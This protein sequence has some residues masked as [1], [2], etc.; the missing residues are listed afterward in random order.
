MGFVGR[1]KQIAELDALF[2]PVRRGRRADKGAAVLLRGRRRIGKSRLATEFAARTGAPTVA[3]EAARRAPADQELAEFAAAIA[4]SPLPDAAI[5]DGAAPG[6]LTAALTLLDAA[7]PATAPSIVIIDEAPWLLE[8]FPGGAGELQRVWDQ[9]LSRKPVLLLLVGSDISAM[10]Q[11]AGPDQPFYGRASE[12]VLGPLTPAEVAD[13]TGTSGIDAFDALLITGGQ[14]LIAQE[15]EPGMGTGD[16]LGASFQR[17]TSALVVSG[18]RILD[19]RLGA[20][21]VQRDVLTAIGG[22]GERTF[23]AIQRATPG[24]QLATTTVTN[25]LERLIEQRLIVAEEP[26]SAKPAHKLR[27]Y[28]IADPA[29]RYWLAFVEP[30]LGD[31]DRGRPDLALARHAAGYPSWR[32]RAI[33]PVVRES[34]WRCLAG[35]RW[36]DAGAL[37]GWWNRANRPEIDLVAAD[38]RPASRI[39]FVG[40]V[41]WRPDRPVD[42]ADRAALADGATAVLGAGPGTDLVAVCPAG[43]T[44]DAGFAQVWTAGDLLA[45]WADR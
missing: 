30:A 39:E 9:R 45:A 3:F 7:L 1:T 13:M 42:A 36:S 12:M 27:R 43:G 44:D 19:G 38:R 23:A 16:F 29:L 14:P 35:T 26:L 34:L 5:A 18:T 41:K 10:E 11:L 37:G 21:T 25:T 6:T 32:G 24:G 4:A 20:G 2:E 28:R 22:R 15:W 8:K 40:T 31:I 17:S 33:E